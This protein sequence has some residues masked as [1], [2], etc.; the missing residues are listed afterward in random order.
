MKVK[1]S[2]EWWDRYVHSQPGKTMAERKIHAEHIFS[3]PGRSWAQS[4]NQCKGKWL[5]VETKF[6]FADQ[7][8]IDVPP[9]RINVDECD[10]ICFE[11]E[12]ENAAAFFDAVTKRYT[13]DWP[14]TNL[15]PFERRF[16]VLV[17]Q[18]KIKVFTE[19]EWRSDETQT[20]RSK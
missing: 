9:I 1:V 4:M 2:V 18:K 8:N 3:S 19:A 15:K 6:L 7:F 16:A 17:K 10:G 11:P 12:F 14:G 20:N 13:K 5:N